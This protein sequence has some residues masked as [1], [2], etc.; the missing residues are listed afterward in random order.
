MDI[1]SGT[2]RALEWDR[3]ISYLA[4][5]CQAAVSRQAMESSVLPTQASIIQT[6]LAETSEAAELLPEYP[7]A[8]L[9]QLSDLESTFARLKARATLSQQEL[10]SVRTTLQLSNLAKGCFSNLPSESFGHL[11]AYAERLSSVP[12]AQQ[13]IDDVIDEHGEIKDNA[14]PHLKRLRRETHEINNNIKEELNRLIRSSEPAKA[15]QEPLYTI[16]SGRFVLPVVASMRSVIPGIV[17]DS[18]ASGLTVYVEPISVVEMANSLRIKELEIEHEIL[19][20]LEEVSHKL[21]E[22]KDN[23]EIT[24]QT[25]IELDRIFA[26][27][28]LG[29]KYNGT[30]PRLSNNDSFSLLEARHPLLALKSSSSAVVGND[31]ALAGAKENDGKHGTTLVITGPNT[32]GKTVLL[33]TIGILSLMLRAGLMLPVKQ[34]STARIFQEIYADI[35]DEQ[36]LEQSLSTFSAHMTNIVHILKSAN[37]DSLVLLDEVGAGTDPQEGAALAQAIMEYLN[38]LGCLTVVTTHLVELKTLAYD[39]SGFVNGSFEFDEVSLMPT[40]RLRLGVA[41]R[42]Q[43]INIAKHLGLDSRVVQRTR[44]LLAGMDKRIQDLIEELE[45]RIGTAKQREDHA[46]LTEQQILKLKEE[47]DT[48]LAALNEEER[49]A[50][51]AYIDKIGEEFDAAKGLIRQITAELQ[52]QPGLAKAQAAQVDLERTKQEL[53]WTNLPSQTERQPKALVQVGKKVI[54]KSLNQLAVIEHLPNGFASQ[55]DPIVQV[56]VGTIK[57]HVPL[58]DLNLN[59]ERVTAYGTAKKKSLPSTKHHVD[60]SAG[61]SNIPRSSPAQITG[62]FLV[63]TDNNTLDLRGQR[64]DEALTKLTSFLNDAVLSGT[65]PLMV[66]HGHGTGALKLAVRDELSRG[67]YPI[68]FR[69]GESREGGDGVTVIFLH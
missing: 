61:R 67:D 37:N 16:R 28:R 23:I 49:T 36:S 66:I 68:D 25:L 33:K 62:G 63:R 57:L 42:S 56:R 12:A 50:R 26:R 31:I 18:S 2:V 47:F 51:L 59:S 41:G 5:E 34:G 60:R 48:K 1:A 9:N 20:I 29:I 21:A 10:K 17:H 69:A 6:L 22:H 54:V 13:A 30:I 40:Y 7:F 39:K 35:G 38:D 65:S 15:L 58:S 44:D 53:G 11:L 4:A 64:V 32:G 46:K 27:A 3:L 52:K 14:S 24:H 55:D 19:R 8:F 45:D 43:A